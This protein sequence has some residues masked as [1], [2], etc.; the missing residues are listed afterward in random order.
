MNE[1]VSELRKRRERRRVVLSDEGISGP[2][3]FSVAPNSLFSLVKAAA[4]LRALK[5]FT[6]AGRFILESVIR[7]RC[8]F[9]YR[10]FSRVSRYIIARMPLFPSRRFIYGYKDVGRIN[11]MP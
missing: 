10:L 1:R 7:R 5:F 11:F 9:H 8:L 6:R 4:T 2:A 3:S